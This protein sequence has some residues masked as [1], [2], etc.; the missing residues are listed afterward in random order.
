MHSLCDELERTRNMCKKVL[1]HA[2]SS[3]IL[4][5]ECA[6]QMETRDSLLPRQ[7]RSWDDPGLSFYV[8][9]TSCQD[10]RLGPRFLFCQ[11]PLQG[12]T[13][14]HSTFER[15]A[16]NRERK[17]QGKVLCMKKLKIVAG[18][19]F[20]FNTFLFG[21]YYS[22]A[23]GIL[24]RIDPIV[25]SFLVMMT[26]LPPALCILAFS[27]REMT[28]AAAKS[29]FLLGSCLCLGL[30]TLAVA[31]KYNSATGTAFFP[32]LNGLLA[33]VFTWLILRQ[34][35]TKGTWFAGVIS[36]TGAVLLMANASMGGIRGALIAFIGGLF[37]TFYIFLAD[38]EQKDEIPYW[39][40][41]GIELLTM[42]AWSGL[43][44]LL[45]GDW[46]MTSLVLPQDVGVILYIG[47]GTTFLP[48]LI[49]VLL[50]KYISPV[51]VSFIYILEPILGAIVAALYLH[52][53]LPLDGYLGGALIVAGALIN[54]WISFEQSAPI[55]TDAPLQQRVAPPI[56]GSFLHQKSLLYPLVC[57]IVG[58][59]TVYKL[60]GFP[61]PAW[62]ELYA[63]NSELLIMIQQGQGMEVFLLIAQAFS[64]LLAW[65]SL[66][67]LAGL[68]IY[69]TLEKFM[70]SAPASLPYVMEESLL[71]QEQELAY[72]TN[73]TID[74]RSLRQMGYT[75][76]ALSSRYRNNAEQIRERRWQRRIRLARMEPEPI[77]EVQDFAPLPGQT[78]ENYSDRTGNTYLCWDDFALSPDQ[79][80]QLHNLSPRNGRMEEYED[81]TE[82]TTTP[83]LI[84]HL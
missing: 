9:T 1:Y 77:E 64:W 65:V 44:A 45:F 51:T 75:P 34:P 21:S 67:I 35:I 41:F 58:A 20:L 32:S 43:V 55:E 28:Y 50:Q 26:L 54:T 48:T 16:R 57:S 4:L 27:W 39:P 30:C 10:I 53:I 8:S 5:I 61:P 22:V 18:L 14:A 81:V 40:L 24:G 78:P 62:Q 80:A 52:E 12:E 68:A 76:Y 79:M 63:R 38:R 31:L 70:P 11:P 29:G 73:P 83:D 82:Y 49:T 3:S 84:N 59:F 71:D 13:A 72:A 42:G 74:I 56:R 25:F 33:A 23:K 66:L 7:A 19:A 36:V 15:V 17:Q 60:G 46:H 47:L 2:L 69:R 37:C 6:E